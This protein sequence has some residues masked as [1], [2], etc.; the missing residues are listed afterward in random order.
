MAKG[1]VIVDFIDAL[2]TGAAEPTAKMIKGE[3]AAENLVSVTFANGD[4]GYL[5]TSGHRD[6]LWADVLRSLQE[7]RQPAYVEID[8]R[9]RS[10]TQLLQPKALTVSDIRPLDKGPDLEVE[11]AISHARHVLRRNHP[12]FAALRKLL[13]SAREE[14]TP[15]WVTET[16]DTHEIIDVRPGPRG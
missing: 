4:V 2:A 6:R 1:H 7:Q 5:N 12:R 8:P 15:V 9:S 11:L 3:R 10:I 16:L 13:R 14:Q